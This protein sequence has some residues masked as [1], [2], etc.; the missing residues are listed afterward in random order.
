MEEISGSVTPE[1][2]KS[3]K[4]V[5]T[6]TEE[7]KLTPILP[8]I[9]I[10][11]DP[12]EI[13]SAQLPPLKSIK[14]KMNLYTSNGLLRAQISRGIFGDMSRRYGDIMRAVSSGQWSTIE[15]IVTVYNGLVKRLRFN[16]VKTPEQIESAVKEMAEAGLILTK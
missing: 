16:N 11:G 10:N 1:P 13:I 5:T 2:K 14:Y 6:I 15:E 3:T 8:S 4:K 7:I 12:I 9:S